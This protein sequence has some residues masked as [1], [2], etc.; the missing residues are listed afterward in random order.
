MQNIRQYDGEMTMES[1]VR[2]YTIECQV[3]EGQLEITGTKEINWVVGSVGSY[4]TIIGDNIHVGLPKQGN[5]CLRYAVKTPRPT[6]IN[7]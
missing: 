7:V 6:A 4:M 5:S 2:Y 1:W 3:Q